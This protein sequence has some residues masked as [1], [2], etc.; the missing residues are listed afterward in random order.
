MQRSGGG[1]SAQLAQ[2]QRLMREALQDDASIFQ[3]DEHFDNIQ[4]TRDSTKQQKATKQ[5]K[6]V[7]PSLTLFLML[8]SFGQTR[9]SFVI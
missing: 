4:A 3:Y 8:T 5:K 1:N 7:T 9:S 6:E 2:Q